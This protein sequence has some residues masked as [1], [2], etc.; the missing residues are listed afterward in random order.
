MGPK[1]KQFL[2]DI[3]DD[4][5]NDVVGT[6]WLRARV[7]E[8]RAE[9]AEAA[10]AEVE[11]LKEERDAADEDEVMGRG[12]RLRQVSENLGVPVHEYGGGLIGIDLNGLRDKWGLPPV[13]R[14]DSDTD[15]SPEAE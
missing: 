12:A 3:E 2:K 5:G 7:A 9:I 14:T 1:L 13:E 11:R 15:E 8:I 4:T 6:D 10:E